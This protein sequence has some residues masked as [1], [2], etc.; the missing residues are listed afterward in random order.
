MPQLQRITIKGCNLQ[1]PHNQL[2]NNVGN[3]A[4]DVM[5]NQHKIAPLKEQPSTVNL[6]W[7]SHRM[8]P[9]QR[10]LNE[11]IDD[12]SSLYCLIILKDFIEYH[13]IYQRSHAVQLR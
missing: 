10:Q 4:L 9:Y 12:Y 7:S 6:I 3:Q 11:N 5:Y 2:V 8:I 1:L 13:R